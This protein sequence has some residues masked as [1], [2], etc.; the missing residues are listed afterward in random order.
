LAADRSALFPP[1]PRVAFLPDKE[2]LNKVLAKVR[3]RTAESTSLPAFEKAAGKTVGAYGIER[4][5]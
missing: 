5:T 2:G 1:F 4:L 3:D